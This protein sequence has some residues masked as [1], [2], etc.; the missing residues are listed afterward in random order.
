MTRRHK[1]AFECALEKGNA[2]A[3][4]QLLR[5]YA[6]LKIPLS[7][8]L[9][10]AAFQKAETPRVLECICALLKHVDAASA[11]DVLRA[12]CACHEANRRISRVQERWATTKRL[13]ADAATPKPRLVESQRSLE[14]LGAEQLAKEVGRRVLFRLIT[15][16]SIQTVLARAANMSTPRAVVTRINAS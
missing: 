6:A 16:C 15:V 4:E 11:D 8:E 9:L 13:L 3:V 5:A 14:D 10:D 7:A 1:C 12:K 2:S